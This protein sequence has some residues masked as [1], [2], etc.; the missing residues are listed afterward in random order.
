MPGESEIT[1]SLKQA[2]AQHQAGLTTEASRLYEILLLSAPDYPDLLYLSGLARLELGDLSTG[3][4]RMERLVGLQPGNAAAYQALGKALLELGRTEEAAEK[5][6]TALQLEPNRVDAAI[7]LAHAALE[8]KDPDRAEEVLRH[9]I[10]VAPAD[11][12]PWVNLGNVLRELD[13]EDDASDAWRS[14]IELDPACTEARSNIAIQLAR[15]NELGKAIGLLTDG[16]SHDPNSPELYCLLGS[17][18]LHH[19]RHGHAAENLDRALALQPEQPRATLLRAQAAVYLCD[20]DAV[21]SA[22]PL[23]RSEIGV[24][25]ND[26]PCQLSPFFSLQLPTTEA[27]RLA[28]AR[29]A[30]A[31]RVR[32]LGS[33]RASFGPPPTPRTKDRLH[34]GYLSADWQDHPNGQIMCGVFRLHDREKFE[35]TVF[36]DCADDGSATRQEIN[37]NADRLVD[38]TVLGEIQAA[39]TIRDLDVDILVDV[40]GFT[41]TGRPNIPALRPAPVLVLY[42]AF[43]STTGSDWIDYLVADATVIP[44]SSRHHYSEALVCLPDCYM[45][46]NNTTAISVVSTTREDENLPA[47]GPVLCSFSNPYKITR[48]IFARWMRIVGRVPGSVLWLIGG[49]EAFQQNLQNAAEDYGINPSRLVFAERRNKTEHLA[50]HR[51]ADLFLDTPIYGAHVSA[52]DS[53]W[54]GTPLLTCPGDTFTARV[55][56]TFLINLGLDDLIAENFDEYESI[57]IELCNSPENLYRMRRRLSDALAA[58]PLFDTPR[59]VSNIEKAYRAMWDIAVAADPPREITVR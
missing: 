51:H 36:A 57:A 43:C 31:E 9:A 21:E 52:L 47:D 20:W 49:P 28:V 15:Q 13:R 26:L 42:H 17:L 18:Q 41:G 44:A 19:G 32:S 23:I 5:L 25:Q 58:T 34:I 38:V 10:D 46:G 39:K 35:I 11:T 22:M 48:D 14:A 50:R 45:A 56:A 3:A 33:V 2:M 4:R 12:R 16:L 55:G 24:A 29:S 1:T 37:R 30:A 27:E 40:Q 6:V 59:W 53:L 54:A 8:L 7:D